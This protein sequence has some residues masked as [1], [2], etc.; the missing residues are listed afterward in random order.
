MALGDS[1]GTIGLKTSS[2]FSSMAI[3]HSRMTDEAAEGD[4]NIRT[5]TKIA[6]D[7]FLPGRN[8]DEPYL[9]KG[10]SNNRWFR[11]FTQP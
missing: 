9:L 10:T 6:L 7:N 11:H 5:V 2:D 8:L 1:T 3:S 4:A